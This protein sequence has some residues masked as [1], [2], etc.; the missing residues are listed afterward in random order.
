MFLAPMLCLSIA[1]PALEDDA[2]PKIEK[3]LAAS[4]EALA[5]RRAQI[6][7]VLPPAIEGLNH[8][9]G[10]GEVRLARTS[11][12]QLGAAVIP[13]LLPYLDPKG[14]SSP[15][16]GSNVADLIGRLATPSTLPQLVEIIETGTPTAAQNALLALK[17][18]AK[19]EHVPA[20][21]ALLEKTKSWK[22]EIEALTVL[23]EIGDP[24][25]T[26]AVIAK[27]EH[28]RPD[29]R[30]AAVNAL[31]V[32]DDSEGIKA[33]KERLSKETHAETFEALARFFVDRDEPTLGPQLLSRARNGLASPDHRVA[34]IRMLGK[35]GWEGAV[36]P[37][38][39]LA[40][41]EGENFR[42]REEAAYAAYRLGNRSGAAAI[43]RRWEEEIK[44]RPQSWGN[45]RGLA[46]VYKNLGQE[47][48]AIE[49]YTKAIKFKTLRNRD[50]DVS[51][52]GL[53]I[54]RCYSLLDRTREA[55]QCFKKFKI[56]LTTE[57]QNDPE[58][59]NLRGTRHW[60]DLL[61]YKDD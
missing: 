38:E 3:L 29:V 18:H 23:R 47:K 59:E 60:E 9:P 56:P 39:Q 31:I 19:A 37:L 41:S 2:A 32:F 10:S 43:I 61:R 20:I 28:D 13:D 54:A 49:N 58:L 6:Q 45:W 4:K 42:V 57:V 22:T 35:L 5:E 30:E 12:L 55:A 14:G 46:N 21:T 40:S 1:L 51:D 17:P 8:A 52:L 27:L 15:F 7:A 26:S 36:Q 25:A 24:A 53:E 44:N 48:S 11:L 33:L 34:M 16:L 50:A